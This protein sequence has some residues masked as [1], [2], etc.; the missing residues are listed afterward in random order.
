MNCRHHFPFIQL[1]NLVISTEIS[2]LYYSLSAPVV[3][4]CFWA[5]PPTLLPVLSYSLDFFIS[6]DNLYYYSSFHPT[7]HTARSV[8]SFGRNL[9]SYVLSSVVITATFRQLQLSGRSLFH[10]LVLY[11]TEALVKTYLTSHSIWWLVYIFFIEIAPT[12][13]VRLCNPPRGIFDLQLPTL[14]HGLAVIS[15]SSLYEW[16]VDI[17]FHSFNS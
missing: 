14:F 17:T 7:L 10:R 15:H 6:F 13:S 16:T 9:S 8:A 5:H 12:A 2:Q 4:Y 3:A 1:L 11:Q